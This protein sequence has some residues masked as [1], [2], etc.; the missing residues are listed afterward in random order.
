MVRGWL[1]K[2][3]VVSESVWKRWGWVLAGFF[4][5]IRSSEDLIGRRDGSPLASVSSLYIIWP[6]GHLGVV[7]VVVV[8]SDVFACQPL[9]SEQSG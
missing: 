4:S 7:V 1:E 5:K 3:R 6:I 2:G 9:V 8:D